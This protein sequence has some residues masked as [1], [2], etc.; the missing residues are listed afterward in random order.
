MESSMKTRL[1]REF[2]ERDT[3]DVARGLLG[4]LLVHRLSNGLSVWISPNRKSPRIDARLVVRAGSRDANGVGGLAHMVEHM[5]YKGTSRVGTLD[6]TVESEHLAK[7]RSLYAAHAAATTE[8]EKAKLLA[9]IDGETVVASAYSNPADKLGTTALGL[10][11]LRS[12]RR[13]RPRATPV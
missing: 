7:L 1:Q 13:S 2:Y 10:A 11:P 6:F 4:K 12:R 5:T 9:E 3:V 8:A